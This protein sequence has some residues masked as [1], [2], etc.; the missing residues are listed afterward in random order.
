[1]RA[2]RSLP[3]LF[4]HHHIMRKITEAQKKNAKIQRSNLSQLSKEAKFKIQT[5]NLPY[6]INEML[7]EMYKTKLEVITLKSFA[8]WRK[9]GKKVSKGSKGVPVWGMPRKAKEEKKEGVTEEERKEFSFFP[10]AYLFSEK[11][12]A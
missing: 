8:N 1:M 9:E 5:K 4:F 2:I 6:T 12:V 11:Q 7:V 3:T 10:I